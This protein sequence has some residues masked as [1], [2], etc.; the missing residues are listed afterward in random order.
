[1]AA[2]APALLAHARLVALLGDE[3]TAGEMGAVLRWL[4]RT[5]GAA[6]FPLDPIVGTKRLV[7]A[8]I[9]EQR[10][11]DR[12]AFRYPLLRDVFA[13]STPEPLRRR[14]HRAAFEHHRL[15]A[16]GDRARWA[17]L[18][19]HAEAA[20]LRE[21]AAQAY[22]AL[23]E[24]ARTRHAY[25]DAEIAY[26]KLIELS[27]A[28]PLS[29]R[30]G[31]GLVRYRLG[32]YPEALADL[33]AARAQAGAE[34]DVMS[35]VE[36][37]LDEAM[38]LDWMGEYTSSAERVLLAARAR[39]VALA[40]PLV[41]ARRLLGL[42]RS[43]HRRDR[44]EEA[45][46]VLARAAGLAARLGDEGYE[47]RVIALLLLGFILPG[48]RRLEEAAR[49]TDE[50]IRLC[51]ERSDWLHLGAALNNRAL[52]RAYLGDRE[53]MTADFKRTIALGRELGQAALELVGQYNLG[54]QLYLMDAADAAEPHLRAAAAAATRQTGG[55]RPTVVA[56]LDARIRLYRGDEAGARAIAAEIRAREAEARARGAAD[57]V[58]SPSEDVLCSMVEL[59]AGDAGDAAWDEL[60]ARSAR[61]SVGQEHV[62]VLEARA[63]SAL[64][65]GRPA[66]ARR[67]LEKALRAA[68][69]IPCAMGDRLR[70][71]LGALERPAG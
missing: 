44:A 68:S 58:M 36:L 33:E 31:R 61:V 71:R 26:S 1:M 34:G 11:G 22:L 29:A 49:A 40:S 23:A 42:G 32:R 35:E 39:G 16:G 65:R 56:L 27:G 14:V 41:D 21:E 67:E 17:R 52:I 20:G 8:G 10:G 70:R 28:P 43:H 63:L 4:E 6:D 51:E 48:L 60:T 7:A 55:S 5:G 37:F 50:A 19:M 54:E 13:R 25:V 66:E 53:R 57:A 24:Q 2:L 9:L 47:T 18:A 3:V 12:L 64:R 45:A 69:R 62:E 38:V 59:A 15:D 30:R 46:E